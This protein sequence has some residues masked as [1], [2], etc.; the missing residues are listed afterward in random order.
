[1]G[2]GSAPY[3]ESSLK[4]ALRIAAAGLGSV[5]RGANFGTA[6][7]AAA[8]GASRAYTAAEQAAQEYAMKQ[9]QQQ[10]Q[11]VMNEFTKNHLKAQTDALSR[12]KTPPLQ[13]YQLPR[14]QQD[15]L[16]EFERRKA[17]AL[18]STKPKPAGAASQGKMSDEALNQAADL[19][20]TT[21]QMAGFGM[22]ASPDRA[23]VRNRAALRHPGTDIA[24][25]KAEFTKNQKTMTNV[26]NLRDLSG[27]WENTVISNGQVMLDALAG[28]PETGFPIGN[29]ALRHLMGQT[30]SPAIARF[31]AARETFKNEVARL[32]GQ[33]GTG[34]AVISDSARREVD[35]ILSGNLTGRQLRASFDIIKRDAQNK[36]TGY[37]KQV[38]QIR[39]RIKSRFGVS[40]DLNLD[41]LDRQQQQ[42]QAAPQNLIYDPDTGEFTPAQ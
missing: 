11:Q 18:Q 29:Y 32:L 4:S 14:D 8:G 23:A 39:G 16:I 28:V 30:G 40:P 12:E 20:A 37:D 6:F 31:N 38:Q 36:R 25:N 1:M 42:E 7:A 19:Y 5:P 2:Y 33:A 3:A 13:P 10:E 15:A 21:G 35:R 24:G 9:Q 17:E 27:A 41:Q 22:G 34:G 26:Q